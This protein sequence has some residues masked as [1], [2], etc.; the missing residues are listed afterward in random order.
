M[1][2]NQQFE[3]F[4]VFKEQQ[5]LSLE[6]EAGSAF[7]QF[8]DWLVNYRAI[9]FDISRRDGLVVDSQPVNLT[10]VLNRLDTNAVDYL[11]IVEAENAVQFKFSDTGV[12]V[13]A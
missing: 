9:V 3:M 8:R 10:P 6:A 13:I 4:N 1:P 12:S 5:A 7:V 2:L 11:Y